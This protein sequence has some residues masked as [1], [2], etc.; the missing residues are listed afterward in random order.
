M[1][2]ELAGNVL[3]EMSKRCS[4][5]ERLAQTFPGEG[6]KAAGLVEAELSSIG[7]VITAALSNSEDT[8]EA[9]VAYEVIFFRYIYIYIYTDINICISLTV[10]FSSRQNIFRNLS[11][12]DVKIRVDRLGFN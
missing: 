3:N 4:L 12:F 11:L 2:R 9:Y 7:L 1:A 10:Q 8:V 5:V 6:V